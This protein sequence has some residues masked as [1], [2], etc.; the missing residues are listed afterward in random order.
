MIAQNTLGVKDVNQNGFRLFAGDKDG[1]CIQSI[2]YPTTKGSV[3][4]F[5]ENMQ[6]GCQVQMS[7]A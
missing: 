2:S 6:I 7:N 4:G 1:Q 3:I 5:G